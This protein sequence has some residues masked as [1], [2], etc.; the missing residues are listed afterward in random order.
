MAGSETSDS[1]RTGS[2]TSTTRD[3]ASS[4]GE[5]YN[6]VREHGSL[7]GLTPREFAQLSRPLNSWPLLAI[8]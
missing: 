7:G 4:P 2:S 8:T 1:T 3:E 5:Q 6:E